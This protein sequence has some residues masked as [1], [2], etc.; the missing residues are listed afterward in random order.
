[1]IT[2]FRFLLPTPSDP[3]DYSLSFL[4]T[5]IIF[6]YTSLCHLCN[7]SALTALLSYLLFYLLPGEFCI[8]KQHSPSNVGDNCVAQLFKTD[9]HMA[10][11]LFPSISEAM[12]A[13]MRMHNHRLNGRFMRVSFSNRTPDQFNSANTNNNPNNGGLVQTPMSFFS[14]ADGQPQGHTSNEEPQQDIQLQ[15]ESQAQQ[16][17]EADMDGGQQL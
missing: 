1:L 16:Q 13:L 8:H 11:I 7:I 6:H 2:S 12:Y 4:D 14:T 3:L 9:A 17:Q 5:R 15:D 10:L